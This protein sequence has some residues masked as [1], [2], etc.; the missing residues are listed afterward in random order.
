[1]LLTF[2]IIFSSLFF[3]VLSAQAASQFDGGLLDGEQIQI[4]STV[5]QSTSA[6]TQITDG[7]IATYFN[8]QSGNVGWYTFASPVEISAVAGKFNNVLAVEFYDDNYTLLQRYEFLNND[9]VQLLPSKVQGVSIVALKNISGGTR[10]FEWNVFSAPLTAPNPTTINWIQ[11]GDQVAKIEWARTGAESYNVKRAT[12]PGGPYNLLATIKDLAYTDISVVNGTTYYYVVSAVNQAGES[13]NSGEKSIKPDISNY[14]GGLLDWKTLQVGKT[15]TTAT[16]TSREVTDNNTSTN[17]LLT[18]GDFIWYTFASPMDISAIAAK[19]TNTVAVEFYDSNNNLLQRY[20]LLNND[21]TQMLPTV[22][23]GVS[24]VALKY[25]GANSRVYE[26]N[27]FTNPTTAPLPTTINWIQGGDQVAKIEWART[28]AESY[29]VK[30][31]TSPGGPYNLLA[32]V[33][34]LTYTDVSVV[35]GTTY[36][37]VVSA[38]N[39]AGESINSGEKSIRPDA[40]MFTGGL[41]DWKTLQ[42]GKTITTATSTSR[43][44]TDNNTSTNTLLTNGDF[45]WY[46]FTS[47]V[48]ITSVVAKFT[49]N[50]VVEFYDS[51]NN[52][53]EQYAITK[54]DQVQLLP[55]P[56]EAVSVVALK[57]T[58]A[59]SRV[60]EWNV[61]GKG[62]EVLPEKPLNLTATAGNKQVVLNWSNSDSSV[63]E[64]HV[65]RSTIPGGT[66]T[67][68]GTVTSGTYSYTD[69]NVVNG[70]TY[71]YVVSAVNAV[72]EGQNS[73]EASATPK[74]SDVVNPPNPGEG[75]TGEKALLRIIL[76]N[77]IDRE[78]DLSMAEVNAF[79]NWYEGRA[80]GSGNVMFAFDK[81]DNN[82]GP[83]VARKD[84]V[85]YDKILTFEVNSYNT[86][87]STPEIPDYDPE[88]H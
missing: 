85:F 35:N 70:T 59:N 8:L 14:T 67:T 7:D 71:Y 53:L 79:I 33:K 57:Y 2:S 48:E 37:Y 61:F 64:F 66:Y 78:Y 84:Y 15:I 13:I 24:T 76:I 36:Y 88:A 51:N 27:V 45:M 10:V 43:E 5:G 44:V 47:P 58:G 65:K 46:T 6:A 50:V 21:G 73:N 87:T 38:V 9:G 23:Q 69:T 28:G 1:M 30:R 77:G 17:T 12:S 4:G 72:G 11:G 52:L 22:V 25:T 20:E 34:G 68:I 80:N 86:G 62:G 83:F 60:Y 41:L 74:G 19:F 42:V 18:N 40:T 26:W 32:T 31:A 54:S 49:N 29:N 82:K 3:N 81:H 55:A 39:Q 56:V 63:T 75:Q 16:S